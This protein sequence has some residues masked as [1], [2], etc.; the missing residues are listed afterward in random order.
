[1]VD[2]YLSILTFQVVG[3]F[4]GCR[5][6]RF[7]LIVHLCFNFVRTTLASSIKRSDVVNRQHRSLDCYLALI[8]L[9]V[10]FTDCSW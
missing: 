10:V 4:L 1:M 5:A 8:W 9:C 3:Y 2:R 7:Q 6:L